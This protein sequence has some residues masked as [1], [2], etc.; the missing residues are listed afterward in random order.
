MF[1]NARVL[2]WIALAFELGK[3]CALLL[4]LL[5]ENGAPIRHNKQSNSVLSGVP[6]KSEEQRVAPQEEQRRRR[7]FWR[8]WSSTLQREPPQSRLYTPS[9]SF[10]F[11]PLLCIHFSSFHA[12][13]FFIAA[14]FK[15]SSHSHPH[16]GWVVVKAWTCA[17]FHRRSYR[18]VTVRAP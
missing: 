9:A 2:I 16:S 1:E 6:L 5:P 14:L 12:S 13:F 18:S 11:L 4:V 3:R 7:N 15:L 17:C 10:I 8:I